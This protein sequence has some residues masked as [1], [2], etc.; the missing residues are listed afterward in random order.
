M[1]LEWQDEE[2][3]LDPVSNGGRGMES[4]CRME[5]ELGLYSGRITLTALSSMNSRGA[6]W[7]KGGA[8][9]GTDEHRRTHGGKVGG[10]G[11][12]VNTE[13]MR[14]KRDLL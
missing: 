11:G 2:L 5:Q 9:S 13:G 8:D 10:M 7:R 6:Q 3:E 14:L 12:M 1:A 4:L